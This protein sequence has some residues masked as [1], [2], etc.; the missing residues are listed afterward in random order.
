MKSCR[1]GNLDQYAHA[2]QQVTGAQDLLSV[3]GAAVCSNKMA[4]VLFGDLNAMV[5]AMSAA[6]CFQAPSARQVRD[7]LK[8]AIAWVKHLR[9]KTYELGNIPLL[10]S[11]TPQNIL[12]TKTPLLNRHLQA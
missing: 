2:H 11:S 10:S 5:Y 9:L 8:Q 1:D 6:P 7:Q 3:C 12:L 4:A